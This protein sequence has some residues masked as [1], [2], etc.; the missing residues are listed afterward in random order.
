[1]PAADDA[2]ADLIA[3]HVQGRLPPPLDALI[4]AHLEMAPAARDFGDALEALAGRALDEAPGVALADRDAALERIFGLAPVVTP[5]RPPAQRSP[6]ALPR[7]LARFTEGTPE[8]W[9]FVWFGI[10]R[11]PLGRSGDF[12]AELL[13]IAGGGRIPQ[14]THTGLE[15]TLVLS[16]GFSD[17]DR[18]FGPGDLTVTGPE[19]HHAPVADPEGCLCFTV[20]EGAGVRLSSR[21]GRAVADLVTA[22]TGGR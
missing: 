21:L 15:A 4:A 19:D 3:A 9:R 17:G 2:A 6:D 8:D 14:H 1:M 20:V 12:T 5:P 18:S 16:G 11:R 13:R 22:V 10:R 7:A